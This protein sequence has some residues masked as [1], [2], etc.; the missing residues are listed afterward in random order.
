MH[1]PRSGCTGIGQLSPLM[2]PSLAKMSAAPPFTLSFSSSVILAS[3]S[4]TRSSGDDAGVDAVFAFF[5]DSAISA[6][7]VGSGEPAPSPIARSD[8]GPETDV[9][10]PYRHPSPSSTICLASGPAVRSN[11]PSGHPRFEHFSRGDRAPGRAASPT[12][13]RWAEHH[14]DDVF[15]AG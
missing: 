6:S 4:L 9:T 1:R 5:E 7:G 14:V 8:R 12:R 11:Q 2:S 10:I 15:H 3:R 13:A